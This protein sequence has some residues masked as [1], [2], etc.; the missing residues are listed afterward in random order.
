MVSVPPATRAAPDTLRL[1]DV[2][3]APSA[4]RLDSSVWGAAPVRI[5][6][7]QGR[8][9]VWLL[10]VVDTVFVVARVPDRTA[11]SADVVS[12]CLDVGGDRTDA[13][14]HDDFQLALHRMLDSS[15]VYRGRAGRWE[16]PL[17]DPDW[18]LGPDH[19]GGGWAA[20]VV[21]DSAGWTLV[22]KLDPAWVAGQN[23]RGPA[24]AF[25]LHDDDAN[26][27]DGWPDGEGAT[28][29][30]TPSRWAVVIGSGR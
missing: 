21:E 17:G 10:R 3:E 14:G 18:S 1:R 23:G 22:L 9:A 15:V 13:P 8:A 4:E 29:D 7:G 6:T 26:R 5:G 24:I 20:T 16:A 12:V 19:Q 27:W 25:Q 11:S 30:R 28:L 2:A